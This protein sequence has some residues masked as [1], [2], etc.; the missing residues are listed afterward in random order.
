[1]KIRTKVLLFLLPFLVICPILVSVISNR[2][3]SSVITRE[4]SEKGLDQGRLLALNVIDAYKSQDEQ[5]FLRQFKNIVFEHDGG[6]IAALD[7]GG[8]VLAHTN[9]VEKGSFWI[10]PITQEGLRSLEPRLGKELQGKDP[11]L[12]VL[13]PVF[14][15]SHTQNAEDFLFSSDS[16]ASDKHVR[17]GTLKIGFPLEDEL[18]VGKKITRRILYGV[19]I[20]SALATALLLAY[21]QF[22]YRPI[23]DLREGTQKIHQGEYGIEVKVVS[24]DE[25]GEL[26]DNFNQMSRELSRTTVSKDFLDSVLDCMSDV[27]VVW[28]MDGRLRMANNAAVQ[29][30]KYEENELMAMR[31]EQMFQGECGLFISASAE[32][33]HL[34]SSF[35]DLELTMRDKEGKAIPAMASVAY[36]KGADNRA[37]GIIMIARDMTE[38]KKLEQA[39]RQKEKMSAVG[40]LAAGVAHEINNPLGII[41]GFAQGMVKRLAGGDPNELPLKTIERE[42]VRCKNLV[43]DLLTFSRASQT[44]REPLD[45]NKVINAGLTLVHTQARLKQIDIRSELTEGL[46]R[47]LGNANQIEQVILNIANNAIDAMPNGGVL[48]FKTELLQ[49]TNRPW[50][51][52]RISDTGTGIPPEVLPRIFEPFFTTKPIGKGTGLGLGMVY[53]IVKK[54]SATIDVQSKAGFTEF[55]IRFPA[56]TSEPTDPFMKPSSSDGGEKRVNI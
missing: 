15:H 40:Q 23:K 26:A 48:R 3:V 10:D 56:R 39:V 35:R 29:L 24:N 42:A 1:M 6:Y 53:E 55:V 8:R 17:L 54:H 50:V 20:V 52:M 30:L 38:R 12:Y 43:Q 22:L 45:L 25:L 41:L 33:T 31:A 44:E 5:A 49:D 51:C 19:W 7:E 9:L 16:M 46:P 18:I 47:I 34:N 14:D 21:L 28:Q 32:L 36:L 37:T 4:M 2:A 13:V 27:L 11:F